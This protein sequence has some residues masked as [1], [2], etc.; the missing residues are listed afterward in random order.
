MVCAVPFLTAQPDAG[1]SQSSATV[2]PGELTIKS[3][4]L[5]VIVDVVVTDSSGKPVHDMAAP[6]FSL[7]EDG[8]PQRILSFDVHRSDSAPEFVPP[9]LP[10]LPANSFVNVPPA[11]ERGPLNVLFLDLLDTKTDDQPFARQQL[12]NFVS[13]KPEGARFAIFVLSDGLHLVQGFTD[14]RQQL[15]SV[16]SSTHSS[17]VPRIFLYGDNYSYVSSLGALIDIARFL[18]GLPGHKNVIWISGSFPF[19]RMPEADP[20]FSS[21]SF[22]GADRAMG[23]GRFVDQVEAATNSLTRAQAAVYPVDARGVTGAWEPGQHTE[24]NA[25]YLMEDSIAENGANYYTVTYSPTNQKYDGKLRHINVEIAKHGYHLAY[26]RSYYG[27][28]PSAAAPKFSHLESE[29]LDVPG[30][31]QPEDSLY[32][33]MQHGAPIAH[34]LIFAA[35]VHTTGE[36]TRATPAQMATLSQQPAYFKE[37]NKDGPAKPLRPIPLQTYAIDYKVLARQLGRPDGGPSP[38]L[39]LAVAAF[40]D[41]GKMLNAVVQKAE[42]TPAHEGSANHQ[43]FFTVEERIDVPVTA[44]WLRFAVRDTSTDHIGAMEVALPLAPEAP[45]PASSRHLPSADVKQN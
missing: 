19:F 14:D 28:D 2:P 37:G 45:R 16:L 3:V 22:V 9:K 42:T 15:L 31:I 7:T 10:V 39:D 38:A 1:Q 41:D 25:S 18:S 23:G 43:T 35:H 30:V 34:Q 12:W 13:S 32:V 26:R 8:K 4:V 44:A 24:L 33:H 20:G 36:P 6:D 11:P 5:R 29:L 17:H 40:D 21:L 27:N